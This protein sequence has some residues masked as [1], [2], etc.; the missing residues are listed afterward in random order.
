MLRL[1]SEPQAA[2]EDLA[3]IRNSVDEF[4]M[5]VTQDR[6]YSPVN[7]F[8]RDENDDIQGG[9]LADLWGGWMHI[10]F[11]WVE[12][13]LRK[14]GYGAQLLRAAEEEARAKGCGHAFVETFSFQ[15]RPFHGRF[16]YQVIAALEDYPP[17]HTYYF[18]RKTL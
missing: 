7:V 6:N 17:G 16:G 18:L 1:S 11:L 2:R 14:H 9:I 15:A 8:L 5:R 4:N 10:T 3:H 12:E 13:P